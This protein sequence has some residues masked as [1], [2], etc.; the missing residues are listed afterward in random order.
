MKGIK[1]LSIIGM[2]RKLLQHQSEKIPHRLAY[3]IITKSNMMPRRA[4]GPRE[5]QRSHQIPYNKFFTTVKS[6][7]MDEVPVILNAIYLHPP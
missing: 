7:Y 1:R 2:Q 3:I 4:H 5:L 6:L